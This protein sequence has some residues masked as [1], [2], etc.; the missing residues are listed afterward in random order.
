[1][2]TIEERVRERKEGDIVREEGSEGGTT[3]T[4]QGGI[5]PSDIE[6]SSLPLSQEE[7]RMKRLQHLKQ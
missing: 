6:S 5:E 7:L 4:E 3:E 1:M 2:L